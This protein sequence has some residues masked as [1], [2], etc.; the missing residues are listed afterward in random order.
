MVQNF[1]SSL[2]AESLVRRVRYG[3]PNSFAGSLVP[4][5]EIPPERVGIQGEYDY[6]GLVHRVEDRFKA[7]LGTV[8]A[9]VE[10]RQRG[11]VVILSGQVSSW[12]ILEMLV[13][14][15]LSTT[16]AIE[17]E[18]DHLSMTDPI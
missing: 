8:A 3:K 9:Q 18:I 14:L 2:K 10:V 16:G 5:R 15:A 7:Y 11:G 4:L 12:M 6:Y 13:S 17:V 1:Q